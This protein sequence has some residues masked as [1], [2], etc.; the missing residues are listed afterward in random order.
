MRDLRTSENYTVYA[1]EH[2]L[3]AEERAAA[4]ELLNAQLGAS[5]RTDRAHWLV[6]IAAAAE[7]GYRYDGT[8]YWDSFAAA[9]PAWPQY[10]DRNQI[11]SWYQR[12]AKEFRG[13]TPSGPWARQFPIIAWP[14][15]QAILP[16]YLQRHF[17]EHLYQLSNTLVRTGE[18]TLDEIGDLLSERYYGSSSRFEGFLQQKA[19]TARIVM[20]MRLEDV[21]DAVAPIEKTTLDRFVR[22][23]DKLGSVG[24]RLR[25]ARRVLR[26][27]RF[28][29]SARPG[30]TPSARNQANADRARAERA[31]RPRLTAQPVDAR[32]WSLALA[33]PDLATPLRQAGLSP[34]DLE[35]AKM[36]FRPHGE[37]NAWIP[38]RA[39]F[40]YTGRTTEP[41][42]AYPATDFDIF[43][44]DRALPKVEAALR[45]RLSLPAQPLRLLKIR[46]D[47][48]AFEVAGLHVRSGQS[49]LLVA[50]NA[51]AEHIVQ[52]L[53]LSPVHAGASH[54]WQLSV[55]QSLN[56]TQIGA[57]QSLGLGYVLGVR[58]EPV[59]LSPRWNPSN[60]ALE[61]LDTE[62]ALFC[63]TSDVA[64]REFLLTVDSC[65]PVRL[66]PAPSGATLV[67]LG[68]LPVGAH[69]IS[70][71][72]LG[73]ATG[74]DIQSEDFALEIRPAVPWQ[75]AISGK[76]GVTFA[77][78]PREVTLE[79]L[80]DGAAHVRVRAPPGRNVKLDGRFYGADDTLFHEEMFGR[81]ATPFADDK[82]TEHI[83]MK[84]T[85][86]AQAEH[87]ERAAR[88]ELVISLDEYGS[89]IIA[90]EK[91]A[92]PL[93]WLRLDQQTVRLSDDTALDT[94]ATVEQYDLEAVEAAR[95]VEYQ[96]ALLGIKL[97]GKGGLLVAKHN[98]RR[99]EAVATVI[100]THL[101]SF[102]DL[103]IPATIS[104]AQG[105]APSVINALKRWH[106]AR[107]LMGPMAFMARR[108]AIRALEARL[109]LIMCGADWV[110]A[111]G[112]VRAGQQGIGDLY[113]RVFY[114][115]G[116]A[117]GLRAYDW[118]Y[119]ADEPG[120]ITEFLRLI[121]VYQ[122]SDDEPL[123]RLALKLAFHPSAVSPSNLP[124][125]DA[126][127]RL[128]ANAA[129]IRGAYFARLA[130]DMR[131][132]GA[133]LE[134]A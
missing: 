103:G 37:G 108:N 133:N 23:F 117:A 122:V 73:A 34:R 100:Q 104:A 96:Q 10:G 127:E 82:L 49:Y 60:G 123:C 1:I 40:A 80:F 54:L 58:M 106:A 90:F 17:A 30:F 120:A 94:P 29:N 6:W 126:F 47:G 68:M 131:A 20:A 16:R 95:A 65:P 66:Q 69:C 11:R 25:E 3:S 21:A 43:E 87:L 98:G 111:A 28:V 91:D 15:T 55:P 62:A 101:T 48:T 5:M 78:E 13:L 97:H 27:A 76:A 52:T 71:S 129:V 114:S 84:L 39:L 102:S 132:H 51:P 32:T 24:A 9:F 75:K 46:T 128:K 109:E 107:R 112:D 63:L 118:R 74:A 2:G 92:D 31:E 4:Q 22:D 14:I 26:D 36:R 50:S 64:V 110:G 57:L 124:S 93:R 85:S 35:Q 119:E 56:A 125:K 12:F 81:Y 61:L 86:D 38:G 116:F 53:A 8:E 67:S 33:L 77:L 7:I 134:A 41:L 44:F 18:L 83:V 121:Q 42:G 113:A 99:Y 19:L 79:H 130:A 105:R 88:I 45:E 70:V 72:A 89:E 115:R 59:G